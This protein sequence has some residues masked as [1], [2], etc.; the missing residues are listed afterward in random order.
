MREKFYRILLAVV[1]SFATIDYALS[2]EI[3][4][5]LSPYSAAHSGTPAL[6]KVVE[7][8]NES[9]Q[10]YKFVIE[11]KPGG[12]QI[13]AVKSIDPENSL[14][15]I[16]PAFVDHVK[17]GKLEYS[18]YT[19][20]WA[21]GDACWAVVANKPLAGAKELVVGG[22]GFGNASHLTALALGEKYKFKV[23]YIVFKSNSDALVNMTGN[24]GIEMIIDKY[25]NYQ[26]MKLKNPAIKMVAASCPSRLPQDPK[27]KTLREQGVNAPYIFNI[28]VS[29]KNMSPTRQ[30]AIGKILTLAAT[31]IGVHEFY[32][33][34]AMRPPQFDNVDL[35]SYYQQSISNVSLLQKKFKQELNEN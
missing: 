11:F 31:D 20:V 24:N 14:A 2:A 33:L 4:K 19:P 1:M 3:I 10:I 18:D 30:K 28:V 6:L 34:S 5:I 27:I 21:L 16:A 35:T 12:N 13:I 29:H 7:R 26:N 25:E 32:K 8:A 9:Q 15:V 17:S 23:K 22:V